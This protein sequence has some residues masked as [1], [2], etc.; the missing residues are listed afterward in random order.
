MMSKK[1]KTTTRA[2]TVHSNSFFLFRFKGTRDCISSLLH[3]CAQST[4][5]V[6]MC[7]FFFSLNY[8]GLTF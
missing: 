8:H 6:L 4:K 1:E 7:S 2:N 3:F 5:C